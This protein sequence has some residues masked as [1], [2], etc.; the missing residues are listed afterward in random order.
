MTWEQAGVKFD[1]ADPQGALVKPQ[2]QSDELDICKGRDIEVAHRLEAKG[3]PGPFELEARQNDPV[4]AFI[5]EG[6][7]LPGPF[8]LEVT[9]GACCADDVGFGL[10]G[11]LELLFRQEQGGSIVNAYQGSAAA[12]ELL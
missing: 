6:E 7:A 3:H 9:T 8:E 11:A 2:S 5:L 1:A 12:L 10:P 4:R